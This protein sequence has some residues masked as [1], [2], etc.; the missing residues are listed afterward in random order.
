MKFTRIIA[1][2]TIA[3]VA[4][5]ACNTK[6]GSAKLK[7]DVD[8]VSY[9]IGVNIGQNIKEANM[10]TFNTE[11]F[12]QAVEDVLAKKD[13]KF[14]QE[15][16]GMYLQQYFNKLQKISADK[17]LKEGQEFL[18]KNKERKEVMTTASG[19][20]YEVLKVGT[21]ATPKESDMVSVHY[22]GTLIDG[23]VFDS[24]YDR[25]EPVSF[26]VNGVIPGWTETLQ[27]MKAGSK[28]KVYIPSELGYGA[29]PNPRGKIKPNSVLIFEMELLSIEAPKADQPKITGNKVRK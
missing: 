16:M 12:A 18:K 11:L 3:S 17:N 20:Q 25:G 4:M 26:A 5:T 1:A 19:L 27:L 15:E 13:I 6:G 28:Y 8:S 21:G 14:K 24:S 22:K 2:L 23:T 7:T 29:N 10:P 9:F